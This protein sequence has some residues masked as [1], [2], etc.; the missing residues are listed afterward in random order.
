MNRIAMMGISAL[1]VAATTAGA[2]SLVAPA[3]AATTGTAARSA[4]VAAASCAVSH[5]NYPYP[6]GRETFKARTAGSVTIAPARHHTITVAGVKP[7]TGWHA[8]I[9]S[10]RGSSVDVYFRSGKHRVKF[11]AEVNDRGGLTVTL[12]NCA[13]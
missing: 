4:T 5:H 9:D 1:T 12:R 3:N 8:F 7:A 6:K 10:R 2:L 13:S 11:E